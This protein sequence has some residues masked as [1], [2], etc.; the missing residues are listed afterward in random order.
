M[1][2]EAVKA[3]ATILL[4]TKC[5]D[6]KLGRKSI[7]KLRGATTG[8]LTARLVVGADGPTSLVARRAGLWGSGEHLRCAQVEVS[9]EIP[10]GVAEIYLGREFF[11]GFFGWAFKAGNVCRVGLGCIE[12]E[13]SKSLKNFLKKHPMISERVDPSKVFQFCT[14]IIPEPFSRGVCYE[15]TLLVGDAAG[16]VKPLT[17]GGLYTGLWCSRIAAEV[18]FEAVEKSP[19]K[20]IL[21]EYERRIKRKFGLEVELATRARRA[22]EKMS[23]EDLT[24]LVKL[25]EHDDVRELVKQNFEFDHHGKLIRALIPKIPKIMRETGARRLLRYVKTFIK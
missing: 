4:K 22:F 6:L 9:G 11:P 15:R 3:G 1:A 5:V 19:T 17:R 12:G 25:L 16:Q 24:Q 8:E 21:Q 20:K 18:A 2:T 10:K 13:P 14:D 23:D 7:L